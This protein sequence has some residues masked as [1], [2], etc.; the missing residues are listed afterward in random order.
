MQLTARQHMHLMTRF[1]FSMRKAVIAALAL[2]SFDTRA[3][4]LPGPV[5]A[6]DSGAFLQQ[7]QPQVPP[8]PAANR[9]TLQVE[10]N[11]TA[12]PPAS[13][14]IAV[15]LI[16][17]T[18]N[19][20]FS[21]DTLHAIVAD[22]EGQ[23]LTLPQLD[24]VAGRI[25]AFYQQRGYALAR[26]IIP[27]Q[28]ITDGVVH[29]QV[30]EARY[31]EI[32]LQNSSKVNSR[33]INATLSRLHSGDPIAD[34]PMNRTLLLLS[35]IPGVG[36]HALLKPGSAVGSA[37]LDVDTTTTPMTFANVSL[38]NYGNRY[39]GR[40]RLSGN[41]NIVNPLHHGD[42]LSANVVTTGS[43]MNYGRLAYD[44]LLNG[45][46]T[47]F[48]GSYSYLRYK[49]GDNAKALDAH[50]TAMVAS[51]WA[52]Q[53]L[54]RSREANIYAQLE[55]DEK[56]LRDRIDVS[57]LR[58]DRHL[59]NWV[60][61]LNGDTRDTLFVGGINAWSIAWTNGRNTFDDDAARA[62]DASTARTTGGYSKWNLNFSRLQGLTS[63]D[64]LYVNVAM[65]WADTN[66]D[67]AEKMS[68][69]GPYSVRAYDIGAIS[70]DTGYLA[71]V[72]LRHDLG[73][74]IS[75]QWQVLAFADNAFVKVNRHPW[76]NGINSA[77]LTGT[78][79]GLNWTGPALWRAT[80]SLAKRVGNT[81]TLVSSPASVR[82]W[83]MVSKAF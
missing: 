27:P 41:V 68:V 34:A 54:L 42:I 73:G 20:A 5:A 76:S 67:S 23:S 45:L 14:P 11:S 71:T 17:I 58:T 82:A 66:L 77:T 46:G 83:L 61:S 25:T 21:T 50:G 22:Q 29:I 16:R 79:V 51:L 55:F 60:L 69:G 56:R 10:P 74:W 19:T 39:V 49:L 62:S 63:R 18:G 33:L 52:K 81:S 31:G 44:T 15:K 26:A 65:Q 43:E 7:L 72:E 24:A 48:G 37:D 6:P 4:T 13:Q 28:S 47:R 1:S 40:A 12:N 53:P 8:A 70:G 75:G 78:G 3:D 59:G 2:A 57:D 30:L 9:P 32:H 35:D 64:S 80:L 38:D 36:V